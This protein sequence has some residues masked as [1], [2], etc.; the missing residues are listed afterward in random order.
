MNKRRSYSMAS[1][2]KNNRSSEGERLARRIYLK[3]I[4][5]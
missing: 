2:R 5:F 4:Y 3:S 1:S